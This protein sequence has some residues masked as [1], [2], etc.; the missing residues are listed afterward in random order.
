MTVALSTSAFDVG[1]SIITDADKETYGRDGYILL[2]GLL[3]PKACDRL[4]DEIWKLMPSRFVRDDRSTW[5]GR[6]PDCCNNL[7]TYQRR[8][9]LRFK[10]KHGFGR[11]PVFREAIHDNPLFGQLFSEMMSRLCEKIWVRGLHPNLPMPRWISVN[12]TFGNRINPQIHKPARTFI[13]IPRLPQVPI[14]GHLDVHPIELGMMLYLDDVPPAG[15]GLAIWPGSHR[16]FQHAFHAG[17]EFLPTGFYKRCLNL[18]Q[19]YEPITVGGGKGDILVF[20]NRLMHANTVNHSKDIRYGVLL[21]LFSS[22]WRE[23][24]QTFRDVEPD[25]TVRQRLAA[26]KRIA[27]VEPVRSVIAGYKFSPVSSFWVDHPKLRKAVQSISQDPIGAPRRATAGS[28]CLKVL[29][30]G[31]VTSSTPMGR[32]PGDDIEPT[33]TAN[34]SGGVAAAFSSSGLRVALVATPSNSSAASRLIISCAW[35]EHGTRYPRVR[36]F[37]LS[38][39]V[40]ECPK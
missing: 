31:R 22:D 6:I 11:Q 36:S 21:D 28:S 17:Y 20:H 1:T 9:L 19:R 4:I 7:S 32:R 26:T 30:I 35:W 2:R 40:L 34:R 10:D 23:R 12:E 5:T 27:D 37:L 24:D 29:N 25:R 13:K 18:L 33:S 38:R 39:S 8:G 15:G 16:L 14:F 3:D